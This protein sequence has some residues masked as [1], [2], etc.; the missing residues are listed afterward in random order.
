MR[1]IDDKIIELIR[2]IEIL[3]YAD[4]TIYS[5][6]GFPISIDEQYYCMA[7]DWLN[8]WDRGIKNDRE[9]ILGDPVGGSLDRL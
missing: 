8:I 7:Q 2:R 3:K 9:V 5:L 4:S 1:K 6:G